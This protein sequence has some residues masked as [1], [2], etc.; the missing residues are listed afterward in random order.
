MY[1][2]ETFQALTNWAKNAKNEQLL[3]VHKKAVNKQLRNALLTT[4]KLAIAEQFKPT[5][6]IYGPSQCGKSYLTA[7]FSENSDGILSLSLDQNYNFL[8]EINPP[9][10]RESTALVSRFSTNKSSTN[11][12][13]PI[14]ARL[15]SEADLICILANSYLLDNAEPKYPD[16][17]KISSLLE[18]LASKPIKTAP[19][20][21]QNY[22]AQV[23]NYF[24]HNLFPDYIRER[25]ANIW[26]WFDEINQ[27]RNLEDRAQ[28]FSVFWNFNEG[29]TE[30][31]KV[32]AEAL[33]VLEYQDTVFLPVGSLLPRTTS[34]IDVTV[35]KQLMNSSEDTVPV[36][37]NGTARSIR[38][39]CLSALISEINF[40]IENPKN[41]IFN[42]AD[43][44]DFPGARTRFVKLIE[45]NS[46]ENV[47]EYF[48]RGK[49]DYLFYKLT[50][51]YLVDALVFC[52]DPGP[53]NIKELPNSLEDWLAASKS[54]DQNNNNLFFTLTKFDEHFPD[55][56]GSKN[57]EE[58]RFQ[59]ALDAGLIQPFVRGE[60]SWPINWHGQNFTN[61][62]PVRNPNYPLEGYFE[63]ENGREV[64]V[65]D[66]KLT[67]LD[68]LKTGFIEAPLVQ[69]HVASPKEKWDDLVSVDGGGVGVLTAAIEKLDLPNM[70]KNN[71]AKHSKF[72][73][74]NTAEALSIFAF[75]GDSEQRLKKEIKRFRELYKTIYSVG[76]EGK[77]FS[78]VTSLSI[79]S[80][81]ILANLKATRFNPQEDN[82][83]ITELTEPDDW[84]PSIFGEMA[85]DPSNEVSGSSDE[86]ATIVCNEILSSW[87]D[88][89]TLPSNI[90]RMEQ[91]SSLNPEVIAFLANH[92]AH[93]VQIQ[94]I[95]TKITKK[96]EE[97]DFGLRRDANITAIARIASEILSQHLSLKEKALDDKPV[98]DQKVID[99]IVKSPNTQLVIWQEW[100]E[101][102]GELIKENSLGPLDNT[103][104]HEQN[105]MLLNSLNELTNQR[106]SVS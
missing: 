84:V 41:E 67:R 50:S 87:V 20:V 28:I 42:S 19:M 14:K 58:Q 3:G 98:S 12:E 17:S 4:N 38:R 105:A 43:V 73:A 90:S 27:L 6:G 2:I 56:A 64:A 75:D 100:L 76:K 24:E 88:S 44:L 22:G 96:I 33:E 1:N 69:S 18:N 55:A 77:Y 37:S 79:S 40:E 13:F 49:I 65:S 21:S 91:L 34:I 72:L 92:V 61:V 89:I 57:D 106:E 99:F 47:D 9:G 94:K 102:F 103:V 46:I 11:K 97:W 53:L 54:D 26:D 101:R 93:E 16:R 52:V 82:N 30:L 71:L 5:V 63:Y 78:L 74:E 23:E 29:F 10:G 15:L 32:L 104:D 45:D 36:F 95:R 8:T 25:F 31:F 81:S 70:K 7:K 83:T 51:D 59:N 60:S 48:L 39:S 85:D 80:D 35:L 62:F 66:R 86:Y 68:E